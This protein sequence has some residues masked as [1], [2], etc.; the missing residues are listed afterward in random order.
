MLG[1]MGDVCVAGL[2]TPRVDGGSADGHVWDGVSRPGFRNVPA[3]YRIG[4]RVWSPN[5]GWKVFG[6]EG[7]LGGVVG[8]LIG[9]GEL[10]E[11]WVD[12]GVG[13]QPG[14]EVGEDFAGFG[15]VEGGDLDDVI[16]FEPGEAGVFQVATVLIDPLF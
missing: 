2:A 15:A 5:R 6:K 10:F 11:S 12:R 1:G 16:E 8:L 13:G 3:S 7:G 4:W 9:F 14:G